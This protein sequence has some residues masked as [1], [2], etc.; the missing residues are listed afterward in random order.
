M[1]PF[2]IDLEGGI[3][4]E[5][6]L[7]C[8][9]RD[10][11]MAFW[12]TTYPPHPVKAARELF[13]ERPV[14]YVTAFKELGHYAANKATAIRCRL[15]GSIDRALMYEKIADRIYSELPAFARW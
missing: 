14:G 3:T 1:M 13:P 12:R 5:I 15:D 9:D 2:S 10:D 11:L 8:M 7:D 6:N 4:M